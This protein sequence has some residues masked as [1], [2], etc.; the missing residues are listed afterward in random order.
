MVL[1]MVNHVL[2]FIDICDS[3]L[4]MWRGNH[5]LIDMAVRV[6]WLLMDNCDGVWIF[7]IHVSGGV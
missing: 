1:W 5:W 7:A 4:V 3:V 6:D 2:M